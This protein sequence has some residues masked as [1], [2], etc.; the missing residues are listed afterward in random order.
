MHFDEELSILVDEEHVMNLHDC[1]HVHGI[2]KAL[3]DDS[4]AI[5]NLTCFKEEE[6]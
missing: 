4:K 2:I 1:A 3:N 5:S 6:F